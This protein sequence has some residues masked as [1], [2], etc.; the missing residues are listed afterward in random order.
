MKLGTGTFLLLFVW[1]F[2]TVVPG[3]RSY[4]PRTAGL[5]ELSGVVLLAVY[6]L[7]RLVFACHFAIRTR[8]LF[9]IVILAG[10]VVF[11]GSR[12]IF[13]PFVFAFAYAL[14]E[15]VRR[16]KLP[17]V[18]A[19]MATLVAPSVFSVYV[20]HAQFTKPFSR[21]ETYLAEMFSLSPLVICLCVT[22]LTFVGCVVLD[23]PRRI[24][25][26][27]TRPVLGQGLRTLDAWVNRCCEKMNEA[28]G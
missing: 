10:A 12:H 1:G 24:L 3:I 27:L 14:F 7:G 22:L 9:L 18:V 4:V 15:F 20:I 21:W 16:I 25:A 13:S 23:V 11:A 28:N 6:A 19:R 8:Q 17:R 26:F 2:L 5:G